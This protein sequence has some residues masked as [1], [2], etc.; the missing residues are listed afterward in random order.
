MNIIFLR[1]TEFQNHLDYL[2]FNIILIQSA[3]SFLK[4]PVYVSFFRVCIQFFAGNTFE[5]VSDIIHVLKFSDS[6]Y[7][8]V[9]WDYKLRYVHY[10]PAFI[11][12]I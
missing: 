8:M 11:I 5:S 7:K 1:C 10:M 9:N 3:Y 4:D 12:G 2:N 6:G